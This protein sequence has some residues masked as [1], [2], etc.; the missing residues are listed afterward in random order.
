MA[1]DTNFFNAAM[2]NDGCM[3]I[4]TVDGNIPAAKVPSLLLSIG[5]NTFFDNP[6]IRYFK[7]SAFRIL[8]KYGDGKSDCLS[9]DGERFEFAPFQAEVHRALGRVITKRGVLEAPG[10]NGWEESTVHRY[11]A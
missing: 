8:P 9:I 5:D 2:I 10:P 4:F 6:L 7:A 3:D 1:P 11:M